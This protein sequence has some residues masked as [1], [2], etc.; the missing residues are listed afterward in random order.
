MF[1]GGVKRMIEKYCRPEYHA[2]GVA[3]EAAL[4]ADIALVAAVFFLGRSSTRVEV[5]YNS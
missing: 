2:S 5:R 3:P 4:A 1:F